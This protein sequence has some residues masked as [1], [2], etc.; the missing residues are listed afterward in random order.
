MEPLCRRMQTIL[1]GSYGPNSTS[2]TENL[3]A[4]LES[5]INLRSHI[6]TEAGKQWVRNALRL[7]STPIRSTRSK[8]PNPVTMV[9]RGWSV[10]ERDL[11]VTHDLQGGSRRLHMHHKLSSPLLGS[12]NGS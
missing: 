3:R 1:T 8:R 11:N 5:T 9:P 6:P 7:C 2:S 4:E 12:T 10:L